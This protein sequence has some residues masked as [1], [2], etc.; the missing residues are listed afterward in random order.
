M[1]GLS[2][3]QVSKTFHSNVLAPVKALH[4]LSLNVPRGEFV[5]VIGANG[6]GKSTLLR[7][8]AGAHRVDAGVIRLFNREITHWP[9]HRRSRHIAFVEQLP[10]ARLAPGLTIEENL[11]L[12]FLRE[13]SRLWQIAIRRKERELFRQV[14]TPLGLGLENR[15]GSKLR[16]LSGGQAQALAIAAITGLSAP[17][18]L[19]LDEHCA[20]LDP[21]MSAL[22]MD[23]TA[24]LCRERGITTIMVSHDFE[25]AAHYGDRLIMMKEGR[26]VVDLSGDEKKRM[27]PQS[28]FKLFM[29]YQNLTQP[30]LGAVV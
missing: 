13:N 5:V 26:L 10:G 8:I 3:T 17:Q 28:V 6:S 21:R 1:Y 30:S 25:H 12:S 7:L 14:L 9:E 27:D 24:K 23:I 19:L 2:L 18:L 15:L 11:A 16:E 20:A 29:E 4:Q 22:V